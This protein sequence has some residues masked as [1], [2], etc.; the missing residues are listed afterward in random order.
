MDQEFVCDCEKS[1]VTHISRNV[2]RQKHGRKYYI[3]LRGDKLSVRSYERWLS[4]MV[5]PESSLK[6]KKNISYTKAKAQ[7]EQL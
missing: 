7:S 2:K 3:G 6:R 5:Q 1:E 4:I